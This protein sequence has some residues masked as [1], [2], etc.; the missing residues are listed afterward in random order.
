MVVSFTAN[1]GLAKPDGTELAKNWATSTELQEDNNLI[2]MDKSDITMTSYT[3]VIKADNTDPLIGSG[4]AQFGEYQDI[5]GFIMGKFLLSFAGSGFT[6]GFGIYAISLPVVADATFHTVGTAFNGAA[7]ANSVIGECYINDASAVS[8]SGSGALE[9]ITVSGTSYVRMLTEAFTSPAK[10]SVHVR[11]SM[12]FP[13]GDTDVFLG[14][15][16]YKKA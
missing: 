12:P 9:L 4:G 15:F 11:D 7:G 16:F 3:P 8:T 2:I 10:T 1:I 14:N 5:E 6:S 13:M